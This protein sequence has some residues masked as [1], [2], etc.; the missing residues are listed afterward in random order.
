[1]KPVG[2]S[3]AKQE[4]AAV[5]QLRQDLAGARISHAYLFSGRDPAKL[6]E[7]A[8]SFAQTLLCTSPAAGEACGAC[9]SCRA[10]KRR[11]HPDFHFLEAQGSTLKV[12]QIRLWR[13]FFNYQPQLGR[14]Q[15]FC[16]EGPEHLTAPA[17]N[18][19]LKVLEEPLARTVFLLLTRDCRVLLPTLVSRCRVLAFRSG[20]EEDSSCSREARDLSAS[21]SRLLW[22]GKESELLRALRLSGPDRAAARDLLKILFGDLEAIYLTRRSLVCRK[23]ERAREELDALESLLECLVALER[24]IFFLEANLQTS[25]VLALTLRTVQKRLRGLKDVKAFSGSED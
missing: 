2:G 24:G 16:L 20:G 14:H 12:E 19:L 8:F 5:R 10:F 9:P 22:E 1:M 3:L 23:P 4:E 11:A 21:I 6:R 17:A 7:L 15:V 18:S 25:L 13:P